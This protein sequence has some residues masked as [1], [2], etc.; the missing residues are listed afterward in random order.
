M[1]HGSRC[2]QKVSAVI[3]LTKSK[4]IETA[5]QFLMVESRPSSSRNYRKALL[6]ILSNWSMAIARANVLQ[7]KSMVMATLL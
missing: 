1:I 2:K 7:W 6:K 5:K 4:Q 3:G